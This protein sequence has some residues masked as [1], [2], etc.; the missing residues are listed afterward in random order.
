MSDLEAR[1]DGCA[2]VEEYPPGR[3]LQTSSRSVARMLILV[4]CLKNVLGTHGSEGSVQTLY[5]RL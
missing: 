4:T 2:R 3:Q 5:Y 1:R